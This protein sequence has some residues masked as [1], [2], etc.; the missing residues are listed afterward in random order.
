MVAI[1][2][3]IEAQFRLNGMR[4]TKSRVFAYAKTLLRYHDSENSGAYSSR[5]RAYFVIY[6]RS[7]LR[8]M[9]LPIRLP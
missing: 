1:Y 9:D 8:G 5:L 4:S 3:L 7:S 6:S 2:W